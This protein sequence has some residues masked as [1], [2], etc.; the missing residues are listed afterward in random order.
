MGVVQ[1][2]GAK[3]APAEENFVPDSE[4]EEAIALLGGDEREAVRALIG[5]LHRLVSR[6]YVRGVVEL[7]PGA[8]Q[9][10]WRGPPG[11]AAH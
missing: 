3:R 6:G 1:M 11:S 8:E 4:V 10:P 5:A 7:G 2:P 9:R